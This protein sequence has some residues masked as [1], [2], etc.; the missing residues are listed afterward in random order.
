MKQRRKKLAQLEKLM[1]YPKPAYSSNHDG[2]DS[3]RSR[4]TL[5]NLFNVGNDLKGS[6]IN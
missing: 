5:T 4:K 3:E 1:P 6:L 2:L